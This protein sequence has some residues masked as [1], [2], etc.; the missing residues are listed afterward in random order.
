MTE[1]PTPRLR[2]PY[3]QR[4]ADY[5]TWMNT[6]LYA[7]AGQLSSE[8]LARDRQAFFGS[9]MGTLNHLVVADTIWLKRFS[10]HPARHATLDPVRALPMPGA[11]D[12]L[13][14]TD[15]A[16]LSAHRAMLDEVIV[17]WVESLTED[18]L[19]H[20]LDYANTRGKHFRRELFGLLMHVSTTR[21]ATAVRSPRCCRRPALMSVSP[22][23]WP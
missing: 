16:A 11:L 5:N 15:F 7:A 23:C 9:I 21:P 20:V 8:D 22:T 18:D 6:R 1:D 3:A 2:K 13:V 14:F 4:M 19:D 17:H 12:E 10:G